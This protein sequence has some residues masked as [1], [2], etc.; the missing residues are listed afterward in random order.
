VAW[1]GRY[2]F[3]S[4]Q[5][6]TEHHHQPNFASNK[7]GFA[8][9][10]SD[11]NLRF[12]AEGRALEMNTIALR[13]VPSPSAQPLLARCTGHR[14]LADVN[15]QTPEHVNSGFTSSCLGLLRHSAMA[16]RSMYCFKVL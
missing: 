10:H 16:I 13:F 6:V 4:G 14:L 8:S 3:S 15:S 11:D 2:R 9:T 1:Q 7:F 5:G 12:A